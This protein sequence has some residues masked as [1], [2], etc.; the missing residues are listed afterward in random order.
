[1]LASV[2]SVASVDFVRG[3][4]EMGGAAA[5][6]VWPGGHT[7]WWASVLRRFGGEHDRRRQ[8][9]TIRN[10]RVIPSV[11]VTAA[12][13]PFFLDIGDLAARSHFAVLP[14][15]TAAVESGE[16]E[17]PNETHGILRMR[18]RSAGRSIAIHVPPERPAGVSAA[19]QKREP[20]EVRG[21]LP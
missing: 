6:V 19:V 12:G 17:Q 4:L 1:M 9:G 14:D 10:D 7:R 8:R 2:L 21:S 18:T 3:R 16:A 11:A 13:T 5:T 15:N 20:L